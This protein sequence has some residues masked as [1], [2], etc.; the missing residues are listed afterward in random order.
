MVDDNVTF[1]CVLAFGEELVAL[2]SYWIVLAKHHKQIVGYLACYDLAHLG[3]HVDFHGG[4]AHSKTDQSEL[5]AL[6][7]SLKYLECLFLFWVWWL[8]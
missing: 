5:A 7:L 2:N 3:T 8:R 4:Y 6:H 1:S